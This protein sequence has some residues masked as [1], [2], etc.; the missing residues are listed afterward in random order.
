MV[1]KILYT[2]CWLRLTFKPISNWARSNK[3]LKRREKAHK[4]TRIFSF[5][6]QSFLRSQNM[7]KISFKHSH[8]TSRRRAGKQTWWLLCDVYVWAPSNESFSHV[9]SS[10]YRLVCLDTCPQW[11]RQHG[12]THVWLIIS[13]QFAPK[14][15]PSATQAW[16]RCWRCQG[17]DYH[18]SV[19]W[20][21]C[22]PIIR[23][24]VSIWICM[25]HVKVSSKLD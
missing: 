5:V 14:A 23:K 22:W 6:Q 21:P 8:I 4:K 7:N 1:L 20:N 11:H 18:S 2:T 17:D 15:Y 19:E 25:F 24:I 3:N 13:H 16:R 10:Y 12:R 9:A